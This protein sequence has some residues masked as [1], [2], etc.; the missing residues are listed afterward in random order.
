MG[1]KLRTPNELLRQTHVTEADELT[2]HH[3]KLL[4]ALKAG[5][6]CAEEAR[7]REQDRQAKYYNRKTKKVSEFKP[8]DRVWERSGNR[9]VQRRTENLVKQRRLQLVQSRLDDYQS[10]RNAQLRVRMERTNNVACWWN[11]GGDEEEMRLANTCLKWS[12]DQR[13]TLMNVKEWHGQDEMTARSGCP[14][15]TTSSSFRPPESWKTLRKEK[16]C[17]EM[18]SVV[19]AETADTGVR[20][21]PDDG[22]DHTL[23]LTT[24]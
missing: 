13:E 20:T 10:E 12:C 19:E 24:V 22:E 14:C 17:N 3:R 2:E 8:G 4:E 18:S 6:E 15:G 7:R 9:R 21:F 5:H 11:F 1:R 16:A 23:K